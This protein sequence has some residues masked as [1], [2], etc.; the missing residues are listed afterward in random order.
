MLDDLQRDALLAIAK[1]AIQSPN[2]PE[3]TLQLAS[4]F[5][6]QRANR[7]LHCVRCHDDYDP[8]YA[9]KKDCVMEDHDEGGGMIRVPGEGGWDEFA[10]PCCEKMEDS[11]EPCFE[12]SH[13]SSWAEGGAYW[14]DDDPCD[15]E[16]SKCNPE[17]ESDEED[18]D[19]SESDVKEEG[20]KVIVID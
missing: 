6:S 18:S 1:S 3:E 17:K 10:W 8:N 15:E 7:M 2:A 19:E 9:G 12:G 13:I 4:Q 5:V 11:G 20:K 14:R 16:C